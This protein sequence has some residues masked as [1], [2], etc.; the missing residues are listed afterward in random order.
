MFI[1]EDLISGPP[2]GTL[3]IEP[4]FH[5][6]DDLFWCVFVKSS[7]VISR[8]RPKCL[9]SGPKKDA[10]VAPR[11]PNY[12]GIEGRGTGAVMVEITEGLPDCLMSTMHSMNDLV[13][14]NNRM[15]K[16]STDDQVRSGVELRLVGICTASIS[17]QNSDFMVSPG[18]HGFLPYFRRGGQLRLFLNEMRVAPLFLVLQR[19]WLW[20]IYLVVWYKPS[21]PALLSCWWLGLYWQDGQIL[22]S[23]HMTLWF[24]S[25]DTIVDPY[26]GI[27]T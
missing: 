13:A 16:G 4:R 12:R 19:W 1:S 21:S 3:V 14:L 10:L 20:S 23:Y 22:L 24:E 6:S 11:L 5:S 27:F 18:W 2:E 8:V 17:K 25:Y 7:H 15:E 9:I 26:V